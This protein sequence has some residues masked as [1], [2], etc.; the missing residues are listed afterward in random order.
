MVAK[1]T[2]FIANHQRTLIKSVR[3][4]KN[5]GKTALCI[6]RYKVVGSVDGWIMRIVVWFDDWM[7]S[8]LDGWME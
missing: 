5:M 4:F 2:S 3:Y 7:I 8:R 1:M 6:E